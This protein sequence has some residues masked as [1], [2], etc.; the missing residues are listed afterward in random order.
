MSWLIRDFDTLECKTLG[1]GHVG[2]AFGL[3]FLGTNGIL[4]DIMIDNGQIW[5]KLSA[6]NSNGLYSLKNSHIPF[7]MGFQPPLTAEFR[8]NSTAQLRRVFPY[9]G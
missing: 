7:G 8:L 9:T 2:Y 4:M 5:C 3:L 6:F 1:P